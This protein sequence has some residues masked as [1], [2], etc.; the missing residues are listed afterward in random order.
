VARRL[1]GEHFG[2]IVTF[3]LEGGRDAVNRFMRALP[4]IPFAPTLGD[5]A[6]IIS[7]PGVTSHRGLTPEE[8]EQIGIRE[9]MVR[10]SVGLESPELLERELHQALQAAR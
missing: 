7:H 6:T 1:F 3:E 9:G 5:V 2:S 4:N 10:V 8:R